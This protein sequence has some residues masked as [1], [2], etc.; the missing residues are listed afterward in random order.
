M[1][2]EQDLEKALQIEKKIES[3]GIDLAM[4]AQSLKA[5]AAE[6]ENDLK[7]DASF[8]SFQRLDAAVVEL[9]KISEQLQM[10]AQNAQSQTLAKKRKEE[11]RKL[12]GEG[13]TKRSERTEEN[14]WDGEIKNSGAV[15]KKKQT[16][17]KEEK[18]NGGQG[19]P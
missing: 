3:Y 11:E 7:D 19:K 10:A 1:K 17:T 4:C 16:D 14:E 9:K 18:Q 13:K 6:G 8:A 2:Q 5:A 15:D 12:E